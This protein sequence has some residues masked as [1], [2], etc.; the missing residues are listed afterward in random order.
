MG[1]RYRKH[2]TA[3]SFQELKGQLLRVSSTLENGQLLELA[4]FLHDLLRSRRATAHVLEPRS[5]RADLSGDI[6]Q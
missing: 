1:S 6:G 4:D 2:A 5:Y 3:G